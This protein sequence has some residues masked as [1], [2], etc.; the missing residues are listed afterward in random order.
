MSAYREL[1]ERMGRAAICAQMPNGRPLWVLLA[2]NDVTLTDLLP[3]IRAALAEAFR[4][5]ENVTPEMTLA[6]HR[7]LPGPYV[8]DREWIEEKFLAM[9]RAS[10]LAAPAEKESVK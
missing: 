2:N 8:S 6:Y 3:S 5:L 4:T 1:V 10:P 9:L 7:C